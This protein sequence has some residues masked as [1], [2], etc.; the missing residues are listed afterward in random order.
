MYKKHVLSNG[1]RVVA[2]NMPDR[3][4]I[5]IGI[6]IGVGGRY[7][8]DRVKG[9][10]HF[11]EHIVFKGSHKY[12]CEEIKELVEG[13]GGSMN[14]FTSEEQTCYYAK[15]P[16]KHFEQTFDILAD[17]AFSPTI[18]HKDVLKERTV[19][20]EEI[21]MYRDLPQYYVLELLDEL[22]WPHHPLGKNLPGT[23]ETISAMKDKDLQAFHKATYYPEN[24]VISVCGRIN[25]SK[26]IKLVQKRLGGI[27]RKGHAQYIPFSENP[28]GPSFRHHPRGI[29]QLHLALGVLGYD[30]NHKDRYVLSLL[31]VILGGNMSSRLFVEIREKRGLAYSIS[32][33]A[34]A[35]HDTGVFM[36]RA[37]LDQKNIV[38]A[39]QLILKELDKVKQKEVSVG[40]FRRAKDYVLGQ[41][42]LNLEDTMEHM[43]WL[44][45]SVI[46]K[47]KIESLK[48]IISQFERI[49]RSDVKRVACG[50]LEQNRYKMALVGPLS[51][52]QKRELHHLL[53]IK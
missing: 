46:S 45:E 49:Q 24:I 20:I 40:E 3:D 36:I 29:E 18:A 21:K 2:H 28:A 39:V 7:E 1:L 16:S 13:V 38:H 34:K 10:A 48:D 4:S 23:P 35:L 37:G 31:S 51:D 17:I 9:V 52:D 26:I 12:K 25:D 27:H 5:S 53:G 6:W 33:S 47:N 42:L 43:L 41:F 14:A 30:E 44:G 50:I 15:I 8:D 19:I 11:L 32:C 22:L